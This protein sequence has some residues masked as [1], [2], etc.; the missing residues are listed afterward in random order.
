VYSLHGD[1]YL[2]N[3]GEKSVSQLSKCPSR[4]S[5]RR[6]I[7]RLY[8]AAMARNGEKCLREL[9]P[10]AVCASY[11]LMYHYLQKSP[12]SQESSSSIDASRERR[13]FSFRHYK[14]ARNS[15]WF[16]AHR[17]LH[18]DK[19]NNLFFAIKKLQTVQLSR[20]TPWYKVSVRWYKSPQRLLSLN[21]FFKN[22]TNLYT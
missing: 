18:P 15:R 7:E 19:E 1:Y 22:P 16:T 9:S 6:S 14:M 21:K 5:I 20:E 2:E 12:T 3:V 8:N 17:S 10:I 4:S 13:A 11:F